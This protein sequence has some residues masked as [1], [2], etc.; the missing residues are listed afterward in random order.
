[1]QKRSRLR[2][3][4]A[5]DVS[6]DVEVC[7]EDAVKLAEIYIL[8]VVLLAKDHSRNISDH[9]MKIIDDAEHCTSFPWGSFCFDEFICN[10]SHLLSTESVKK[11]QVGRITSYT[12]LGFPF[13]FNIWIME[14][15]NDFRQFSKYE[16][17][18]PIRM[19]SY[20]SIGC[21]KYDTLCNDY[22]TKASNFKVFKVN[23]SYLLQPSSKVNVSDIVNR[24]SAKVEDIIRAD[25]VN[26]EKEMKKNNEDNRK[27]MKKNVKN[28]VKVINEKLDIVVEF[29]QNFKKGSKKKYHRGLLN[30]EDGS[31]ELRDCSR[32]SNEN[33]DKNSEH[34]NSE[35]NEQG[36]YI[37][38]ENYSDRDFGHLS[39]DKLDVQEKDIELPKQDEHGNKEFEDAGPSISMPAIIDIESVHEEANNETDNEGRAHFDSIP[40]AM[41]IDSVHGAQ[42]TEEVVAA[43][44]ILL[45]GSRDEKR[46]ECNAVE[47]V[48]TA[49]TD[50]EAMMLKIGDGK[51]DLCTAQSSE[52][53]LQNTATGSLIPSAIDEAAV[54]VGRLVKGCC[55]E[56]TTN[57]HA[58]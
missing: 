15:F 33:H 4:A 39:G 29:I 28:S 21:L 38:G 35:S 41:D 1:M 32:F 2:A 52:K 19:L 14:V 30:D 44:G 34:Q 24:V 5:D 47:L 45:E 58:A 36:D 20:S 49:G 9:S 23:Q 6:V 17:R 22:F 42:V 16:D 26:F 46:P 48:L 7:D 27:K 37:D 11:K 43:S 12:P 3:G 25:Q 53:N 40:L 10:L 56:D 51:Q 57:E 54:V 50:V 55:E 8:E 18:G 13:L 31:N